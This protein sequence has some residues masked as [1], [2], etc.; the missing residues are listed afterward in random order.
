MQWSVLLSG[1][2]GLSLKAH[3]V[4]KTELNLLSREVEHCKALP[5]TNIAKLQALAKWDFSFVLLIQHI[6]RDWQRVSQLDAKYQTS[7]DVNVAA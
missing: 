3:L 2:I 6:V 1:L 4:V 7:S 5:I